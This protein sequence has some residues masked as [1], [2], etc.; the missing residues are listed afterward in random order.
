MP[1]ECGLP[2]SN[3]CDI[4]GVLVNVSHCRQAHFL[5]DVLLEGEYDRRV[6]QLL[7]DVFSDALELVAEITLS[8][9]RLVTGHSAREC[10]DKKGSR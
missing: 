3:T 1:V 5:A 9:V 4:A 7:A 6:G 10:G 2:S 8:F